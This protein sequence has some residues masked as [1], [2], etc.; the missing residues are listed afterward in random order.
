MAKYTFDPDRVLSIKSAAK[1]DPQKI[2]EALEKISATA[3]GHL[4]P[5]AVVIAAKDRKSVLHKHFEWNDEKAAEAYRVDQARSLVRC[6]HIDGQD[7]ENG[8]A[9]AFM[10]IREKSGTSYRGLSDI[11]GSADLQARILAQAERDLLAWENRYKQI[12]DVCALIRE[13]RKRLSARRTLAG[14]DNR[15]SA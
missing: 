14:H 6:I 13:A 7:T 1:A 2:G 10:S 15:V 4:T 12:E 9:R 8:I 11:L 3:G 5:E